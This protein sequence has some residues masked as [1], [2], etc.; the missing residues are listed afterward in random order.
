MPFRNSGMIEIVACLVMHAGTL[1]NLHGANVGLRRER[2]DLGQLQFLKGIPQNLE[3]A[4]GGVAFTPASPDQPPSDFD[5]RRKG[6][7][8]PWDRQAN[9]TG[10]VCKT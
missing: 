4:F 2:H 3:S 9:E 5:R 7:C 1:H 6:G 10:E 8:E